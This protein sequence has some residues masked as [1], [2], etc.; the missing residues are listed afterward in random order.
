MAELI[1]QERLQPCLLDRLT[2][3]FPDR[4]L[5]SREQ[6]VITLQK[7]RKGVLRDLSWLLNTGSHTTDGFL[8]DYSEVYK[9]VLNFGMPD[10]CGLTISGIKAAKLEE[11]VIEA[12]RLFEPRILKE[13]LTVRL[14]VTP[15]AIEHNAISFEIKGRLW[16]QP[17]P[18]TLYVRTELDLETG[19]C[20]FEGG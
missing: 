7:Y 12:I 5:E 19:Q 15:E 4:R 10:M 8:D 13:S 9:S 2:D 20:M 14:M 1:P 6:R 18:D 11:S 17:M 3:E 16:A